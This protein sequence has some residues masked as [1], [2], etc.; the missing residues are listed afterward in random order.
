M[1]ILIEATTLLICH[2]IG[3]DEKTGYNWSDSM[4]D[5]F[6]EALGYLS[7]PWLFYLLFRL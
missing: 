6:A 5:S 3:Y 7:L 2:T 1:N 4:I